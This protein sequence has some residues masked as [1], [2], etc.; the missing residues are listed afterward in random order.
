MANISNPSMD[1]EP[2]IS[3]G[4]AQAGRI[5]GE[6]ADSWLVVRSYDVVSFAAEPVCGWWG[7][8][9]DN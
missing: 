4:L 1:R 3:I 6:R 5:L 8:G 7:E 9:D 2:I